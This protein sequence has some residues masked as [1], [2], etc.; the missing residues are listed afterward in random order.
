MAKHR[1]GWRGV[2]WGAWAYLVVSWLFFTSGMLALGIQWYPDV[3]CWLVVALYLLIH[4]WLLF[5]LWAWRRNR[6]RRE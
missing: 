6:R 4:G 3:G 1:T 5:E 2:S